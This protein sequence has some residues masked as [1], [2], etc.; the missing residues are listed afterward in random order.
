MDCP[1][2]IQDIPDQVLYY[3]IFS[4]LDDMSNK[5]IIRVDKRFSNLMIDYMGNKIRND[6]ELVE[7]NKLWDIGKWTDN[8]KINNYYK[9][10]KRNNV[11]KKTIN[12]FKNNLT[13]EQS[14]SVALAT[15]LY[16]Q[17]NQIT[18]IDP[19]IGLTTCSFHSLGLPQRSEGAKIL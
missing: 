19:P 6:I 10:D 4:K 18:V 11:S 1:L 16:L 9:F 17:N 7:W 8:Q 12:T 15:E 14:D 13:L 2:T 5:S 3:E